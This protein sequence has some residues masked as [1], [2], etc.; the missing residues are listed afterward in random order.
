MK[1]PLLQLRYLLLFALF[2]ACGCGLSDYQNRMDAQ[3][4]RVQEFDDANK[5]LG[6]PIA[7]PKFQPPQV[8]DEG[9]AWPFEIYLRL[10]QGFDDK[11]KDK[12]PYADPFPC[13]RYA[14]GDA[15]VNIFV[16]AAKVAEANAKPELRHYTPAKFRTLIREALDEFYAKTYRTTSALQVKTKPRTVEKKAVAA[17]PD[18][19]SISYE[20]VQYADAGNTKNRSIFDVY[21]RDRYGKQVAI[22]VHQIVQQGGA[23]HFTTSIDACLGTLDASSEAAGKRIQFKALKGQ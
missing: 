8:K 12:A 21:I 17:Y 9:T 13:F 15:T 3:S 20:H 19:S 4:K 5:I 22:V 1:S 16:V 7:N 23:D 6:D 10:P 14:S 11:P 2:A 18:G